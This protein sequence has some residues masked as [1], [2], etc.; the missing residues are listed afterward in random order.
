MKRTAWFLHPVFIFVFSILALALSLFLYIYWYV[1]VSLRLQG[2]IKRFELD[3]GKFFDLQTWVV[4]VILSILVAII[5]IG[6]LIIFLYNVKA[7]NLYRLQHNFIN[8]FTHELK[9]PVTS[10]KLYLETFKKYELP[11]ESQ[12]K[13]ID[14]VL[15]DVG[16]LAANINRILN[17]AQFEGKMFEGSFLNLDIIEVVDKFCEEN[18][19]VFR[20]ATINVYNYV[21]GSI[22]C[23]INR[24]LF[25]MLLMNLMT[26]A[27]KYNNSQQ[28]EIDIAFS[29]HDSKLY[30][31]FIDNGVGF[32]KREAKK[33]FKKFYQVEMPD[34]LQ[35]EGTGLGLYMVGHI[36]RIH[37]WK[38]KAESKG[39]GC[40]AIFTITIPL[41]QK[42]LNEQTHQSSV[43]S[44]LQT[45]G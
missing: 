27:M 35:G 41:L 44:D 4:I 26:N 18:R 8:S 23:M 21:N 1:E 31:T 15:D 32:E 6:I 19:Q 30:L 12:L 34:R 42:E 43:N 11:R 2:V 10:M 39:A 40:G 28:P 25:E 29:T 33:I 7:V 36:A 3:P 45:D 22:C 9:T 38:V 5:L 20:N 13:Y 17:L 24:Q 14:Y 16:R 37:K